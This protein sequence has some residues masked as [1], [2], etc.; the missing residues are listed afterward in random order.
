MAATPSAMRA[1][2]LEQTEP[3]RRSSKADV[4]QFIE[5]SELKIA[6]LESQIARERACVAALRHI[7]SPIHTLPVELLTEI[8]T[9][10][11]VN[12]DT[13]RTRFEYR[14]FVRIGGTSPTVLRGSGP[15][16]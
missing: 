11:F 16:L 7:F 6:S 4:Q 13:S 8:S 10:R 9:M 15:G 14:K 12:K 2:L 1:I 5:E 3:T